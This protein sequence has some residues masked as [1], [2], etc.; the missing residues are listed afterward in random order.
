MILC[1]H[2]R[3]IHIFVV[4][5]PSGRIRDD[6]QLETVEIVDDG[7]GEQHDA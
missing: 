4:R 6:G 7:N 3:D 5:I 1:K 2:F